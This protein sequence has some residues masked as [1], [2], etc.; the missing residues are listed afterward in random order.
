MVSLD[1]YGDRI[2]G[3][4][5]IPVDALPPILQMLIGGHFRFASMRGPRLRYRQT[6]CNSFRLEM[7]IDEE[8]MPTVETSA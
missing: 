1:A 5:S 2:A 7:T 6:L 3:L 4:V 8:D